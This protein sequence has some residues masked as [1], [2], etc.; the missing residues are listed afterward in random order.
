MANEYPNSPEYNDA[1]IRQVLQHPKDDEVVVFHP[2]GAVEIARLIATGETDVVTFRSGA[3]RSSFERAALEPLI[4]KQFDSLEAYAASLPAI[5]EAERDNVSYLGARSRVEHD[6]RYDDIRDSLMR[7]AATRAALSNDQDILQACPKDCSDGY[8]VADCDCVGHG[9]QQSYTDL[10]GH[11]VSYE[12]ESPSDEACVGCGGMGVR[13]Y[14]CNGCLGAGQVVSNPL[15]TVINNSTNETATVR[16]DV[17]S[18]LVNN[19]ISMTVTDDRWTRSQIPR[20]PQLRI[21]YDPLEL[22]ERLCDLVGIDLRHDQLT[23][24]WGGQPLDLYGTSLGHL[25]QPL[26]VTIDKPAEAMSFDAVADQTLDALQQRLVAALRTDMYSY[27]FDIYQTA[28]DEQIKTL[29]TVFDL[30]MNNDLTI[31]NFGLRLE[32]AP[33]MQASLQELM[34]LLDL[35]TLRLGYAMTGIATGETGPAL[36]AMDRQGNALGELAAGNSIET[37]LQL[38]LQRVR[39]RHND[40]RL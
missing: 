37:V 6:A 33:S 17:A 13:S 19:V 35:H 21:A 20:Q 5:P 38:A 18:L 30:P 29:A 36:Y 26:A 39:S 14:R 32:R 22:V 7:C 8:R 11:T 2:Q 1:F 9:R 16:A 15:I 12:E 3:S 10:D 28:N 25:A 34:A 24:Y 27:D 4:F 31:S 40:G 23:T